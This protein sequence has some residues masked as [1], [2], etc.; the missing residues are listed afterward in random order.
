M[1][2]ISGVGFMKYSKQEEQI[3]QLIRIGKP[4]STA[5]KE[6]MLSKQDLRNMRPSTIKKRM[7]RFFATNRMRAALLEIEGKVGDRERERAEKE[8]EKE[9]KAAEKRFKELMKQTDRDEKILE[10]DITPEP[11]MLAEWQKAISPSGP[12]SDK[13]NVPGIMIWGTGRVLFSLAF[14]EIQERKRVIEKMMKTDETAILKNSYFSSGALKAL[15]LAYMQVLPWAPPPT[16]KD[17]RDAS[18]MVALLNAVGDIQENPD[19]FL[20]PPPASV[21]T[22]TIKKD[23]DDDE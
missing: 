18:L 17:N 13:E 15:N 16:Q 1:S 2:F 7:E 19:D 20:A 11:E 4:K 6:V 9:K 23:K 14:K 12:V 5:Y 21:Q 3:L 22:V 10:N 8:N